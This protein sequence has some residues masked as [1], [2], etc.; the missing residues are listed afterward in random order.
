MYIWIW[1]HLPGG[2]SAKVAQSLVLLMA[3]AALLLL[4]VFPNADA[5]L[6]VD[7]VTVNR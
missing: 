4:V 5:L 6:S 2:R 1:R 7:G 3:A